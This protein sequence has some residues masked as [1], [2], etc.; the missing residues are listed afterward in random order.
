M[1]VLVVKLRR[2][3]RGVFDLRV[4]SGG[5]EL[6]AEGDHPR[7][8]G[9]DHPVG[10]E[11][12][13]AKVEAYFQPEILL[14]LH[15]IHELVVLVFG[16][17]V[18]EHA[19]PIPPR[20]QVPDVPH[21]LKYAALHRVVE[22]R[23]VVDHLVLFVVGD[24]DARHVGVVVASS[25]LDEE[26]LVHGRALDDVQH[27]LLLLAQA[28]R[29]EPGVG[30]VVVVEV[31]VLALLDVRAHALRAHLHRLLLDAVQRRAHPE[32]RVL[33]DVR[34]HSEEGLLRPHLLLEHDQPRLAELL[35]EGVAVDHLVLHSLGRHRL[36]HARALEQVGAHQVALLLQLP[37]AL[38]EGDA[39]VEVHGVG[40]RPVG[41][42]CLRVVAQQL[43]RLR[44]PRV[45]QRRVPP[46]VPQ[47]L[48]VDA[49]GEQRVH[50]LEPAP[51]GGHVQR[52]LALREVRDVRVR[53]VRQQRPQHAHVLHLAARLQRSRAVV[54]RPVHL[55]HL[56][57]EEEVDEGLVAELA[58]GE[59]EDGKVAVVHRA[60][61]RP[62]FHQ[63][64]CHAERL[65]LRRRVQRRP[66][67]LVHCV[68][69]HQ[70]QAVVLHEDVHHLPLVGERGAVQRGRARLVA[71]V[72][73]VVLQVGHERA[74]RLVLPELRGGV[75]ARL[76][77][78]VGHL[79]VAPGLQ[80]QLQ[81]VHAPVPHRDLDR[82]LAL[83][84]VQ[85][86]VGALR[87]Q[88][89]HHL[90]VAVL[91]R[92]VERGGRVGQAIAAVHVQ[93]IHVQQVAALHRFSRL[94]CA[95]ERI[96]R[97]EFEAGDDTV[98]QPP[99]PHDHHVELLLC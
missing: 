13:E 40:L 94:R 88:H 72:G 79:H 77:E 38:V 76:A 50:A 31:K 87:Q 17:V 65:V 91:G 70:L 99:V 64:P 25:F 42:H 81:H 14:H 37:P 56:V 23:E 28:E 8:S 51:D 10:V 61:V 59:V 34:L 86:H 53:A 7:H 47:H 27:D 75:V 2:V 4:V 55:A 58:H 12:E 18:R 60:R 69:V 5:D 3:V 68:Q 1:V 45:V 54:V 93:Q 78:A 89:R 39:K 90:R 21:P 33:V 95:V 97:D 84:A 57:G 16:E 52:R 62:Q 92:Q 96:L 43:E 48:A 32:E 6:E 26:R 24:G 85:A 15:Q 82:R 20:Q 44:R 35:L 98:N 46:L 49:R 41:V 22:H 73:D 66:P 63:P 74:E 67:E 80:Q 36:G 9:P 83:L 71:E 11:C 30:V 29:L 19:P